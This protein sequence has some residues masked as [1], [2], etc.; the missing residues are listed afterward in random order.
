MADTIR[1]QII[2]HYLTRLATWTVANGYQYAMGSKIY[3]TI[4]NINSESLPFVMVNP[5]PETAQINKYGKSEHT[6]TLKLEV[7]SSY[8]DA[9]ENPSV[10][11]E[12]L[13]GECIKVMTSQTVAQSTLIDRLHYT[14][15][16]AVEITD[17][18]DTITGIYAN[19]E[20]VYLTTI[21]NPYSQS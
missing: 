12:A 1:E 11:Q 6:F 16:G 3:R 17:S 15:G 13:L 2:K 8:N 14:G 10:V 4:L 18:K 19:F 5:Q 20:I 7:V 21:G 9:T